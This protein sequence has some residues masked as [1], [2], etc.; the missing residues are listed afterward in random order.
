M[1]RRILEGVLPGHGQYRLVGHD[2]VGHP[3]DG[4]D[5]ERLAGGVE[6]RLGP[7]QHPHARELKHVA[8]D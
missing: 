4:G 5:D 3:G 8:T 6:V 7:R 1:V 2:E